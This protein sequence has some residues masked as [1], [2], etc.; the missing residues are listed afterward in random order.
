MS[1][2]AEIFGYSLSDHSIEAQTH[3]SGAWC[4]F[5][6]T[7]CDGGGNRWLTQIELLD[8]QHQAL[9]EL[10][11]Q[12]QTLIPGVC[13]L[14]LNEQS[15]PWIICPHRLLGFSS[16]MADSYLKQLLEPIL[17]Y[18]LYPPGTRLGIWP[19]VKIEYEATVQ[20]DAMKFDYTFDYILMPLGPVPLLEALSQSGPEMD[21]SQPQKFLRWLNKKA[22][23]ANLEWVE[24]FPIGQ[25]LV[26]EVM[27]SSTSG[28]DK[29]KTNPDCPSL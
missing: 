11:P 19:E 6:N 12:R 4:P 2:I 27:S 18:S 15:S 16:S 22:Y 14:S 13:S 7:D 10:Y 24:Q 17:D 3:R 8:G 23:T 1:K 25:P 5:M 20:P 9:A 29:K 26:L 21:T 28:Q